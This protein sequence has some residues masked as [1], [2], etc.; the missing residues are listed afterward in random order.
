MWTDAWVGLPY[1]ELGRGP[2]AYDC[3]GL[4]LAVYAARFGVT[5]PDP[6]ITRLGSARQDRAWRTID[7]L[8]ARV[9]QAQEGDALLFLMGGRSLHIGYALNRRDMLHLESD[10]AMSCIETWRSTRWQGRLKGIYRYAG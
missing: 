2:E 8:G 4:Y 5:I 9:D 10:Q 1:A 7:G 3:L 6:A